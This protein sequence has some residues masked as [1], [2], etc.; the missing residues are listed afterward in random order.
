MTAVHPDKPRA[1]HLRDGVPRRHPPSE[2]LS[3][4]NAAGAMDTLSH[5]SDS[6]MD[7]DDIVYPCKG[8]GEVRPLLPSALSDMHMRVANGRMTYRFSR[9]GRL[10]N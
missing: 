1:F 5:F 2:P 3:A 8:C 4:M 10:L 6:P 9:K 7:Q